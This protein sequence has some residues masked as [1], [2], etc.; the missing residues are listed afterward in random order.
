MPCQGAQTICYRRKAA[1]DRALEEEDA[2]AVG[3]KVLKQKNRQ[4]SS[5]ASL[6]T[7]WPVHSGLKDIN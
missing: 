2:E 4:V 1:G 3:L 7:F 6:L 5:Y